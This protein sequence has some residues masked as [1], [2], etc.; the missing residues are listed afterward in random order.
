VCLPSPPTLRIKLRFLARLQI[1]KKQKLSLMAVLSL[2]ILVVLAAIIRIAR[3]I[4]ID[5]S[6]DIPWDSYDIDIWAA[7]EINAGI[8]CVSAPAVKPL[9]RQIAPGLL[10]SIRTT[11]NFTSKNRKY[12][13]GTAIS[14]ITANH[15]GFELS[16]QSNLEFPPKDTNVGNK[17]WID[18]ETKVGRE[19]DEGASGDA[20]SE[21]A[22]VER[23]VREGEIRKTVRVMVKGARKDQGP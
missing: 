2:S 14:R 4:H 6:S 22:I 21:R 19:S 1:P 8:F 16:S 23:E 20:E 9:L 7:V 17:S 10:S 12:G 5:N 3:I 13:S 18:F 15:P 11:D